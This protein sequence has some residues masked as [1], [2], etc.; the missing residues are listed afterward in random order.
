LEGSV[1][2]PFSD[3][4]SVQALLGTATA[5]TTPDGLPVTRLGET[6]YQ[7]NYLS[8]NQRLDYRD[9]SVLPTEG[10]HLDIPLTF[11]SAV[12]TNTT[13][14]FQT[15]F[16]T[17]YYK[18]IG[19]A[20]QLALGAR[21]D[22]IMPSG[23]QLPIDLRLFNGG[24]RSVRSYPERELGPHDRSG[25]PVGGQASWVTNIE[26]IHPVAG[27]LKGV[28]F[29][30][31]GGLS[32]NWQD[33]GMHE[34]DVALGLGIRFDLPIGPVRFEYGHNMTQDLGEP[35]G[36]WHFAIGTAF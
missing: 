16:E 4:Y 5:S 14:Y 35:S 25:Y 7:N 3:H 34:I 13:S 21:A 22:L 29:V 32:T 11:G 27:A 20:G 30:D 31:A 18:P 36:T 23:N 19:K 28:V 1:S 15:G 8:L 10:W 6:E 12:G 17:S 2:Y 24:P 33:F 26:Y 9:S